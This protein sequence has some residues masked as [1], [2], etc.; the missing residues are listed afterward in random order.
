MFPRDWLALAGVDPAGPVGLIDANL[1][2]ITAEADKVIRVGGDSPWLAHIEFQANR[3]PRLAPRLCQILAEGLAAGESR[4]A[5]N[6][7][8]RLLIRQA[9][10][11]LGPVSAAGR[12]SIERIARL[13][14][15]ERPLDR[16]AEVATWEALLALHQEDDPVA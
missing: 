10:R 16:V 2:T 14:Q 6:E 15:I 7:A 9:E 11:K 3:G 1:S 5:I 13:E 8:R 12:G 4:G